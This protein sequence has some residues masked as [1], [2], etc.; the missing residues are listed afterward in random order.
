M[1]FCF[2]NNVYAAKELTCKYG[3]ADAKNKKANIFVTLTQDKKGNIKVTNASG[4]EVKHKLKKEQTKCPAYVHVSGSIYT[5]G[6]SPSSGTGVSNYELLTDEEVKVH[7]EIKEENN[8]FSTTPQGMTCKY[9]N[10]VTLMVDS[11]GDQSPTDYEI[12]GQKKGQYP[13]TCPDHVYSKTFFWKN[14]LDQVIYK[15]NQSSTKYYNLIK[16][17]SRENIDYE[18]D[19]LGEEWE[20]ETCEEK[21]GPD[22]VKRIQFIVNVAKILVPVLL[23]VFG[24]MDFGKAIFV[25]DE[26]EMKKVQTKFIRRLIVAACF[27]LIP[28]VLQLVLDIAS[29]VWDNID[30]S[31]CG[32]KF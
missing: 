14:Q 31:L 18:I 20:N 24:I 22:L 11:S 30:P 15:Q 5:F 32:I 28:S 23:I 8:H 21:L 25:S 3:T 27:F 26:N 16:N 17:A 7:D 12:K 9:E 4:K 13:K 1:L 2:S 19:I 29:K 6:K 10:G